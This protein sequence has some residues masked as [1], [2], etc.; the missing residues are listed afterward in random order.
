MTMTCLLEQYQP[1]SLDDLA[2][3]KRHDTWTLVGLLIACGLLFATGWF[4]VAVLLPGPALWFL[5]GSERDFRYT[6]APT[7]RA[8]PDC[9]GTI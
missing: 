9:S 7:S 6:A 8:K 4:I 3:A 2:R 1:P 5:L